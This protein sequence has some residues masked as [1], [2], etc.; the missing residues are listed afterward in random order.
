MKIRNVL[1]FSV[2]LGLGYIFLPLI[3]SAHGFDATYQ[4]YYNLAED[5]PNLATVFETRLIDFGKKEDSGFL[6][7]GWSHTETGH[8]WAI[9]KEAKLVFYT[10]CPQLEKTVTIKCRPFPKLPEQSIKVYLNG[11]LLKDIFMKKSQNLYE[12]KMPG[13]YQKTF[14]NHIRFVFKRCGLPKGHGHGKDRRRLAVD[15]NRLT[16][17][18]TG[19]QGIQSVLKN[20]ISL[21]KMK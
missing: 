12:F 10:F 5:L 18:P 16:I 19:Y 20:L 13:E 11:H 1:K 15:F 4:E 14:R 6:V 8:T 3:P 17:R 9:G 21:E 2:V 7:S